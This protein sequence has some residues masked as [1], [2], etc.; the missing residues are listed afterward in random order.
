MV[1]EKVEKNTVDANRKMSKQGK[2]YELEFQRVRMV[3][4]NPAIP[5]DEAEFMS[6]SFGKFPPNL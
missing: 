2:E 5:A 1:A 4:Q 6:A 3:Y